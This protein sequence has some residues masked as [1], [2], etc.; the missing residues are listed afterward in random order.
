MSTGSMAIVTPANSTDQSDLYP[1]LTDSSIRPWAMTWC[2]PS[3]LVSC[4]S[5][6]GR[7]HWFHWPSTLKMPTLTRP[8]F[9][10]GSM[11]LK[12]SLVCEAPSTSAASATEVGRVLK[13]ECMKK[14]VNDSDQA[15]YTTIN[16]VCLL[17]PSGGKKPPVL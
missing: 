13:N 12:N 8:G 17:G 15:T 2:L 6:V 1:W 9:D 4:M 14:I 7:Y 5:R 16:I 3:P 10:I 11:T